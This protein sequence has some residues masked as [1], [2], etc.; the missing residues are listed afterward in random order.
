MLS[1]TLAMSRGISQPGELVHPADTPDQSVEPHV[2]PI[3][4]PGT[5]IMLIVTG[6]S[7]DYPLRSGTLAMSPDKIPGRCR[8]APNRVGPTSLQVGPVQ[9]IPMLYQRAD[10]A[11]VPHENCARSG[12]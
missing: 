1:R 5:E 6:R 10:P 7:R 9:L 12:G 3:Q 4:N 11:N 2:K 8:G